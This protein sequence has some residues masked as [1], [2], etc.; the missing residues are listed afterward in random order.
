MKYLQVNISFFFEVFFIIW[1]YDVIFS[2]RDLTV[3]MK[4]K[5]FFFEDLT[6]TRYFNTGFISLQYKNT[7]RYWSKCSNEIT[8]NHRF[9]KG[10]FWNFEFFLL[11]RTRPKKELGWNRP[12]IKR[13][14]F[15]QGWPQPSR[16]GWAD[17]PARNEHRLVT[18]HR[19]N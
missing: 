18:V 1:K 8:E 19:V 6:K 5:H 2:L 10:F 11:D 13:A 7:N 4:T 12:K 3:C 17:V 9:L 15:L 16:M 14:Y